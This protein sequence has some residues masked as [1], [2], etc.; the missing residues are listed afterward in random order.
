MLGANEGDVLLMKTSMVIYASE[1]IY[2]QTSKPSTD[3]DTVFAASAGMT[4]ACQ[5][6]AAAGSQHAG[7]LQAWKDK[8]IQQFSG[9]LSK[10]IARTLHMRVLADHI[11]ANYLS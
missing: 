1:G 11:P 8:R 6:F 7:C 4:A 2:N 5:V 3:A 10:N 9:W